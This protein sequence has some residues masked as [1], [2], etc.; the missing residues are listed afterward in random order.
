MKNVLG[1]TLTI[2][3]ILACA[4]LLF[5][6]RRDQAEE[7]EARAAA[8][9]KTQSAVGALGK[10]VDDLRDVVP[11][12]EYKLANPSDVEFEHEVNLLGAQG[13]ELVFARRARDSSADSMEYEMVFKRR[14]LERNLAQ[15]IENEKKQL[16]DEARQLE[17]QKAAQTSTASTA[18]Q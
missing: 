7:R 9:E 17:I 6:I 13:W 2:A 15:H 1:H 5:L 8:I 12:W 10:K 16:Q 3:A 18:S 11:L 4:A 14:V